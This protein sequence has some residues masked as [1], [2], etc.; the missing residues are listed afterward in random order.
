MNG[1]TSFLDLSTVY[2]SDAETMLALRGGE[3]RRRE[4]KLW[5][6]EGLKDFKLPKR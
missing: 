6:G 2:G 4:G 3:G 1:V 5:T